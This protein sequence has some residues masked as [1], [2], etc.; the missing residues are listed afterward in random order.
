MLTACSPVSPSVGWPPL[1]KRTIWNCCTRYTSTLSRPPSNIL[2]F[3]IFFLLPHIR[4]SVNKPTIPWKNYGG[5][6]GGRGRVVP[7]NSRGGHPRRGH[8]FLP[9]YVKRNGFS[10]FFVVKRSFTIFRL[11]FYIRDRGLLEIILIDRWYRVWMN[12]KD[13]K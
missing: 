5:I 6:N 4:I 3:F 1:S 11:Y 8:V 12:S 10:L 9:W 13:N 2:F 7:A